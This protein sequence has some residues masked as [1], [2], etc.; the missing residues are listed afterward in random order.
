MKDRLFFIVERDNKNEDW[1]YTPDSQGKPQMYRS[2]EQVKKY[3]YKFK[4]SK[5][6]NYREYRVAEYKLNEELISFDNIDSLLK[7][8]MGD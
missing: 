6:N 4:S 5:Y 3:L 8:N 7:E 1:C 2:L